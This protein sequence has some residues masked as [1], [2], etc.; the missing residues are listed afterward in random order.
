MTQRN[1]GR[2]SNK[3]ETLLRTI[4]YNQSLDQIRHETAAAQLSWVCRKD[5]ELTKIDIGCIGIDQVSCIGA[6]SQN[7]FSGRFEMALVLLL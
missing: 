3:D 6:E 2:D 7:M 1:L 4:V 5:E